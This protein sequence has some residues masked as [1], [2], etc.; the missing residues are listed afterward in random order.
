MLLGVDKRIGHTLACTAGPVSAWRPIK[1]DKSQGGG[2][3]GKG[4]RVDALTNHVLACAA[5]FIRT[6][7]DLLIGIWGQG[8]E[9]KAHRTSS[10]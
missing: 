10:L 1:S 5:L 2:R 6:G 4:A 7:K 3:F 8:S 9:S